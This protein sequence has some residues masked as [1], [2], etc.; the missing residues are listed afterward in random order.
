MKYMVDT[1]AFNRLADRRLTVEQLPP[2]AE[3]IATYVQVEEINRTKDEQRR[4]QLLIAFTHLEPAM[5]HTTSFIFGKTPL[6]L[7]PFGIGEDFDE[8][9]AEL[10]AR[11]KSRPS[12]TNDALIAETALT[13]G[14]GLITAD[15]DL[16]EVFL[17]R[18]KHV[19]YV[20]A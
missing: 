10:D 9:K 16:A 4:Y 8:L 18:S 14:Y 2:G 17:R 3:L 7:A 20:A 13:K 12:N 15:R 6:G 11:N 19:I 1:S 5:E